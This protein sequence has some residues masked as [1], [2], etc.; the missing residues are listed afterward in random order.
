[1]AHFPLPLKI[2]IKDGMARM[3]IKLSDEV[4]ILR[5]FSLSEMDQIMAEYRAERDS[6]ARKSSPVV[7]FPIDVEEKDEIKE[8]MEEE[9]I[10]KVSNKK[11]L[12]SKLKGD[13]NE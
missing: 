13:K 6:Y 10:K 1:M 12:W 7:E 4:I 9:N 5:E 8:Y 3:A 2:K 11:G